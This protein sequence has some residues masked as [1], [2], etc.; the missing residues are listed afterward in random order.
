VASRHP[1]WDEHDESYDPDNERVFDHGR[2]TLVSTWLD[3]E[4][5][6]ISKMP[7]ETISPL[8]VSLALFGFFLALVFQQ[9]WLVLASFV[10]VLLLSYYWLWP[11]PEGEEVA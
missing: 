7:E 2:L 11:R 8:L 4:P 1:L 5:Y 3:A 10:C 6:A 9:M